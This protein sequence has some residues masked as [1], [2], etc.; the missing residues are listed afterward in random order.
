MIDKMKP[1]RLLTPLGIGVAFSLFG[2]S[3]LYTVLPKGDIASQAGISLAMVGLLLGLNRV[4][5]IV[6]NGPLGMLFDRLPRRPIMV[7]SLFLGAF[8]TLLYGIGYG[9]RIL[10]FARILWGVCWS[11]I[12]IGANTMV[13]DIICD[14]DRGHINGRLQMW[15]FIGVALTNFTG[16]LFTDMFGYRGGLYLSAG[17]TLLA[18]FMWMIL[19]PETRD[20]RLDESLED[21]ENSNGVKSFP[22]KKTFQASY[23]LFSVRLVFAGVLASTTILWLQQFFDRGIIVANTMIPIAT[24]TGI[25]SALRILISIISA[26]LS[27]KLSDLLGRRWLV[28]VFLFIIGSFGMF[29][30]AS[31]S[32]WTTVMGALLSAITGGGIQAMAPSLIGDS[33]SGKQHGRTLSIVFTIGDLGSAIGPPLALFLIP[34]TGISRVYIYCAFIFII[35]LL[36]AVYLSIRENSEKNAGPA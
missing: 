9:P 7:V 18:A 26:P 29:L 12:W 20:I 35:S 14:E 17:L 24:A 33:A 6:S 11:G 36:H 23:P 13:L 4:A 8:S 10:I 21:N 1:A 31:R 16:G 27:G 3:T 25:F 32:I 34:L 30:M 28:I 15:F 19:L 5:R 2:D 22:W